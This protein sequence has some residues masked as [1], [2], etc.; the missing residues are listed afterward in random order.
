MYD[1]G[2]IYEGEFQNDRKHGFGLEILSSF[3]IYEG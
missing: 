1:N 2:R 3:G